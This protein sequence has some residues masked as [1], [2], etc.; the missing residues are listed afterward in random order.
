MLQDKQLSLNDLPFEKGAKIEVVISEIKQ[1]S[2]NKYPLRGS[3]VKYELPFS[4]VVD[5]EDWEAAR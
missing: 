5:D 2:N 1:P 3:L 4:T